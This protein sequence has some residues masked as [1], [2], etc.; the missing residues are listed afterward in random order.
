MFVLSPINYHQVDYF[1][2]YS[3]I[4]VFPVGYM[5]NSITFPVTNEIGSEIARNR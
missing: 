1:L 3:P 4:V 2:I 5:A